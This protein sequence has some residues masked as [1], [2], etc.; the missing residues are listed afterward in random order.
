[1]LSANVTWRWVYGIGCIYQG[2]VAIAI[3]FFGEETYV[4]VKM[5]SL[6]S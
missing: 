2:L 3:F 4:I 5:F 6:F 1:M